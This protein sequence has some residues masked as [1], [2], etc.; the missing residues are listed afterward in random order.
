MMAPRVSQCTSD[1]TSAKKQVEK[2]DCSTP[3]E[4]TESSQSSNPSMRKI[5][6]PT[7]SK[8]TTSK[9]VCCIK[10]GPR[11]E[12]DM[13]CTR[14]AFHNSLHMRIENVSTDFNPVTPTHIS[15]KTKP[16]PVQSNHDLMRVKLV[17]ELQPLITYII[18]SVCKRFVGPTHTDGTIL[19]HAMLSA[20]M[21][22]VGQNLTIE[23][24][25]CN[26]RQKL[27]GDVFRE[28]LQLGTNQIIHTAPC[29]DDY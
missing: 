16:T 26:I 10:F 23:N 28:L 7:L 3:W 5:E 21:S 11:D 8:T 1:I 13:S 12:L 15:F 24:T 9:K 25:D 29:L 2:I 27:C 20:K 19:F 14:C 22:T 6:S 4:V 18:F 17:I